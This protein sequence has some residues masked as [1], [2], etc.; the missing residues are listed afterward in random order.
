MW[1]QNSYLATTDRQLCPL[2]FPRHHFSGEHYLCHCSAQLTSFACIHTLCGAEGLVTPESA[3]SPLDR[4]K[5][6]H[7][8]RK[9]QVDQD[10]PRVH[11]RG[12]TQSSVGE[13]FSQT[14][15]ATVHLLRPLYALLKAATADLHAAEGSQ[16]FQKSETPNLGDS[17][18]TFHGK[19][20]GETPSSHPCGGVG[21]H[22]LL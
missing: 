18:A 21:C 22:P 5:Y 7:L 13:P 8:G 3:N 19:A 17:R 16:L 4:W 6:Q 9:N 10:H 20:E 12:K 15:V 14:A 11:D 2:C 1:G